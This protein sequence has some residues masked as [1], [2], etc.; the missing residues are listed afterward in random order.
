MK[1]REEKRGG[2]GGGRRGEVDA[3]VLS[4]PTAGRE[5]RRIAEGEDENL[6]LEPGNFFTAPKIVMNLHD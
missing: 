5:K 1:R 3:G 6:C 4:R 2:G